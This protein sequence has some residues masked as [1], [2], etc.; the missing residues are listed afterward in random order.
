VSGVFHKMFVAKLLIILAISSLVI[1]QYILADSIV[2]FV[3]ISFS[4]A[5]L[6]ACCNSEEKSVQKHIPKK[7][8]KRQS[9]SIF[10]II[11]KNKI[12]SDF[13]INFVYIFSNKKI[14]INNPTNIKNS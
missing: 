13:T 5:Q 12:K 4:Y 11:Q 6:Y 3:V 2:G 10:F 14:R 1:F 8:D 7:I 9:D